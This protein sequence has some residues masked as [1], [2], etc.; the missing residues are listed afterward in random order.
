MEI[1]T[2][3]TFDAI[4]TIYRRPL[5][6]LIY[7]ARTVHKHY[8]DANEVQVCSLISVKTGNCQED[9]GYCPQSARYQTEIN[10]HSLLS[11]DEVMGYAQ[12]AKDMGAT[13]VCLG[14]AWRRVRDNKEFDQMVDIVHSVSQL[15]V[16]VCCTLGMVTAEQ[17]TRLKEAGLYAYNHNLDTSRE[18]YQEIISTRSYDDRLNTLENIRQAN[19]KV[20]CG[21]ILGMGESEDD[22]V[23]FLHTLATLPEHPE[24]VPINALVP[25]KGTPLEN[26]KRIEIWDMLRAIATAR[27]IM[28]GSIIRLSAGRAEMSLAEQAFCF[29]AGANSIFAGEKLLTTPN[30]DFD[31]DMFLFEKLSLTPRPSYKGV[32]KTTTPINPV[33]TLGEQSL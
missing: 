4:K 31:E 5:F 9:C 16:E 30:A 1:R 18:F 11:K 20:C 15:G 24:S 22:R 12:S 27:I 14:A 2:D 29:F 7:E 25:V 28:P 21:G 32:I 23:A 10:K 19:I 3:W 13:R 33:E 26:Q 17:A 8:H 6:D